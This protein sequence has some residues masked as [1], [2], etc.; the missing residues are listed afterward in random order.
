MWPRLPC[1]KIGLQRQT[2]VFTAFDCESRPEAAHATGSCDSLKPSRSSHPVATQR[3]RQEH[4]LSL[5]KP[6]RRPLP[7]RTAL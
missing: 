7:A 6:A 1:W 2:Q 5:I 4:L 3:V